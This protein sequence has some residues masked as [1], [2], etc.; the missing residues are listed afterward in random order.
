[1]FLFRRRSSQPTPR[2]PSPKTPTPEPSIPSAGGPFVPLLSECSTPVVSDSL[3]FSSDL[4]IGAGMVVLQ[5]STEKVVL[6]HDS[7]DDRWFMPRGRK[8]VGET[9]EQA[10]IRE[11]Y[12]ESG[13]NAKFLPLF[14]PSRQPSAPNVAKPRNGLRLTSTEPIFVQLRAYD[15]PQGAEAESDAPGRGVEYLTFWY[16][17]QI[18]MSGAQICSISSHDSVPGPHDESEKGTTIGP[19]EDAYVPHLLDFD[20]AKELLIGNG[21]EKEAH[22]LHLAVEYWR[23]TAEIQ[24]EHSVRKKADIA[25]GLLS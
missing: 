17:G 13:Y 9:I 2:T 8:D 21:N 1:M 24:A 23:Y 7:A 14:L 4:L 12:E 16:V 15:I 10:A 18:G 6:V 19:D 25:G 5:P 3:W 11:A 20:E 22:I